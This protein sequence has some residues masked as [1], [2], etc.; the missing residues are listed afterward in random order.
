MNTRH[1]TDPTRN[2]PEMN[3]SAL[4]EQIDLILQLA[5]TPQPPAGLASRVQQRIANAAPACPP[6]RTWLTAVPVGC[7]ALAVGLSILVL[8]HHSSQQPTTLSHQ[9]AHISYAE[10]PE[11]Q[12]V[13]PHPASDS[14]RNDT[15]LTQH[16][17]RPAP[18]GPRGHAANLLSY[19]LT[20]QEQ[21]LVRLVQTAK[22]ADLQILN[23]EYQAKVEAQQEAEFAAYLKSS[24]SSADDTTNTMQAKT[25][26]QK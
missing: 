14:H 8:L 23:P 10:L 12:R 16:L 6:R 3:R 15:L 26:T 4:D 25:T 20:R 19:P 11:P 17:R 18:Y 24:D 7:A 1:R 13:G 5:A 2:K 9:P 22:P 21:L